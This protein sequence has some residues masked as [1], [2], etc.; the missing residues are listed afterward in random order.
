[1]NKTKLG[2]EDIANEIK[3]YLH[4]KNINVDTAQDLQA[5]TDDVDK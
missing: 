3:K 4:I 1:M 5:L 2:Q